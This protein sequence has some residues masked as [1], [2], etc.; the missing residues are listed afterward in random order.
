MVF[1]ISDDICNLADSAVLRGLRRM[2]ALG[3]DAHREVGIAFFGDT[4]TGKVG[5]E[6]MLDI[7]GQYGAALVNNAVKVNATGLE[8]LHDSLCTGIL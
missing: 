1:N 3:S 5:L 4:D 6:D 7:Y 8:S 2:S